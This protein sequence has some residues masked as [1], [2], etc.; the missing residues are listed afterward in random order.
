VTSQPGAA[1][2]PAGSPN[3]IAGDERIPSLNGLRAL[4]VGLVIVGHLRLAAPEALQTSMAWDILGN[5]DLGVSIFFVI[6]GFL[7]TTLLL[8]E[9]E[10]TGRIHLL[11]FYARRFYRI[12]PPFY[13]F[14]AAVVLLWQLNW[15]ALS[16]RAVLAAATFTA[17][18]S[19]VRRWWLAHTWSLAVEEQ[20]YLLWPVALALLGRRRALTASLVMIGLAPALRGVSYYLWPSQ[21]AQLIYMFHARV[22]GLMFGCALALAE[23]ALARMTHLLSSSIAAALA[24]YLFVVSP[25]LRLQF[26]G[27]YLLPLG[28]S[29]EGASIAFLLIYVVKKPDSSAGRILNTGAMGHVGL[30]SYSLYLWQQ[31]FLSNAS[32][33]LAGAFPAG[34][35]LTFAT[36]EL[37]YRTVERAAAAARS[38]WRV[39]AAPVELGIRDWGLD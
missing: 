7:I 17:D 1:G 14:I 18:Y 12:V 6:S 19:P 37:S 31:L 39:R 27:R 13:V 22:D 38:R 34:L 33:F 23:P 24:V 10:K 32:P 28:Y 4:S 26:Q 8:S 16:W 30:I 36:A 29:L 35:L 9:Q 11:A 21:R 5:G 20:F 25:L 15:L 2:A 3:A